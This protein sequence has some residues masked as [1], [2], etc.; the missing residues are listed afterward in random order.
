MRSFR[1]RVHNCGHYHKSLK[2]PCSDARRRKSIC[3]SGVTE[4]A[5]S[6]GS[7]QVVVRLNVE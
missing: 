2:D 5:S 1:V 4:D 6:S 7:P 3:E